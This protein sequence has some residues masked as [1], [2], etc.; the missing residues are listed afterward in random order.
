MQARLSDVGS[1][2]AN[3][4]N[5]E[6]G[7]AAAIAEM[8]NLIRKIGELQRAGESLALRFGRSSAIAA[9]DELREDAEKVRK[10]IGIAEAEISDHNLTG[11]GG[12]NIIDALLGVES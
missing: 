5:R 7:V 8:Q 4:E 10:E 6:H 2:I 12:R 1:D 3:A 11:D 9:I